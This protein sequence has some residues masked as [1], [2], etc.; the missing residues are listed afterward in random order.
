MIE[1]LD[2]SEQDRRRSACGTPPGPRGPR[3]AGCTRSTRRLWRARSSADA[4]GQ[5]AHPGPRL[6]KTQL[7]TYVWAW[8]LVQVY[9]LFRPQASVARDLEVLTGLR[10]PLPTLSRGLRRHS[11]L[12]TPP[13]LPGVSW[14]PDAR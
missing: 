2:V 14:N 11:N 12:C 5:L 10:I 4:T 3:S 9:S 8:W 7:G 13:L 1:V 6:G